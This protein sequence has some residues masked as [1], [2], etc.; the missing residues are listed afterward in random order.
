MLKPRYLHPN[1]CN[2]EW[3][4]LLFLHPKRSTDVVCIELL[5]GHSQSVIVVV[6]GK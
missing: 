5:I 4:D 1:V 2:L 3:L 6:I